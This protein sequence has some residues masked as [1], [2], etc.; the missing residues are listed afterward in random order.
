MSIVYCP[1]LF[2][3]KVHTMRTVVKKYV[4]R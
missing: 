4:G 3:K 2:D 1:A